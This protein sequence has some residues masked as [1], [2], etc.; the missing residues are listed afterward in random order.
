MAS[1]ST[2]SIAAL[3][4]ADA[5]VQ[6][7]APGSHDV[8]G[9]G[10]AERHEQQAGLVD[11]P[12]V[13]VDHRDHGLAL[14]E[15]APQ[16]VG[17]QRPARTAAQDHNPMSHHHQDNPIPDLDR[18]GQRS[19]SFRRRSSGSDPLPR[20]VGL[21]APMGSAVS[22]GL[23][24]AVVSFSG[25]EVKMVVAKA[26]QDWA[27]MLSGWAIPDE[28]VA[29]APAPPFFFD[30]LVFTAAADEALARSEDTPSD[31]L[32][33]DALPAGGTVLDVA[34]GAGA[35]SLRLRPG[36]LVG[37][38]PSEPLLEAFIERA[39]Q[40]GIDVTTVRGVW[41][42]AGSQVPPA[43]VV[44]CHHV[45]YNV[46]NLAAFA[47]ALTDHARHR[48]VVELTAAH[49]MAWMTPYWKAL[50]RLEQ[51]VRPVADDAVA[52]LEEAGLTV[53][54]RPWARRYQMIGESGDQPLLR[55]AR[56]LCLP[57]SRHDELRQL[58][59]EVPPPDRR[60]VVTLWW[61]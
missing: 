26:N 55:I 13:L 32:A 20:S 46:A 45:F 11:V 47:A 34:C 29:G 54:Q 42:D 2:W 3:Y 8:L 31:V 14:R 50:H 39:E 51:P 35:A 40:L 24:A 43:D 36:R 58:L 44:V 10:E 21:C 53:H 4:V 23:S 57:A 17:A 19:P 52:V 5:A 27:E 30:P 56:R 60:D 16:P 9:V 28:L 41:P 1:R 22:R 49:P 25:R 48:V 7:A 12:V 38:D 33:R 6:L 37:V 18:Q 59:A 15:Q 61:N